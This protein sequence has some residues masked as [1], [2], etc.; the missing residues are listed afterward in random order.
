MGLFKNL[1]I[2][3]FLTSFYVSVF[4]LGYEIGKSDSS[5]LW[6]S[7]GMKIQRDYGVLK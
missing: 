5:E 2:V 6:I 3:L 1:L 4:G 7:F